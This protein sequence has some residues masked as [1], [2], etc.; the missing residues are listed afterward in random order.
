MF[1]C[2]CCFGSSKMSQVALWRSSDL[3][4][5]S[6]PSGIHILLARALIQP[7]ITLPRFYTTHLGLFSCALFPS[8]PSCAFLHQPGTARWMLARSSCIGDYRAPPP[9]LQAKATANFRGPR[10]KEDAQLRQAKFLSRNSNAPLTHVI[11]V[12][13]SVVQGLTAVSSNLAT[14]PHLTEQ[15]VIYHFR[16]MVGHAEQS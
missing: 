3:G 16:P 10:R 2:S 9:L 8:Q 11:S 7:H 6:V 5:T 12:L 1:T 4:H 14:R 15:S 13:F